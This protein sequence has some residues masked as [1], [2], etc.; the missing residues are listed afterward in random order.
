MAGRLLVLEVLRGHGGLRRHH[1]AVLRVRVR[2]P[3][4]VVVRVHG[5][6]LSFARARRSLCDRWPRAGRARR[7]TTQGRAAREAVRRRS[8]AE[9]PGE[10]GNAARTT[11][12]GGVEGA[13]AARLSLSRCARLSMQRG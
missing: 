12:S 9:R 13:K 8:R 7:G 4:V 3:V 2:V 10:E 1:G 6:S 11:K 5:A